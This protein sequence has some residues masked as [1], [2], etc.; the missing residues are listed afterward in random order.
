MKTRITT[1]TSCGEDPGSANGWCYKPMQLRQRWRARSLPRLHT[2]CQWH[3]LPLAIN[4]L[5]SQTHHCYHRWRSFSAGIRLFC[6]S[7]RGQHKLDVPRN[8][9]NAA[10]TPPHTDKHG[11]FHR[12]ATTDACGPRRDLARHSGFRFISPFPTPMSKGNPCYSNHRTRH[13]S[14]SST[15]CVLGIPVCH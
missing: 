11:L 15:V 10:A 7:I 8:F 9:S 2:A 12:I 5:D 14:P 4:Y 3:P 6:P 1:T 13:T